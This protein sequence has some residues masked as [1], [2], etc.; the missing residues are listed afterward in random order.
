[1][2]RAGGRFLI[3]VKAAVVT[4]L[5]EKKKAARVQAAFFSCSTRAVR[6]MV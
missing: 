4:A 3:L 2:R 6:K 1:V 5:T